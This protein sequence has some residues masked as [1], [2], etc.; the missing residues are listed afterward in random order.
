MAKI[1]KRRNPHIKKLS[2]L[3]M[4]QVLFAV[5]PVFLL[6][7]ILGFIGDEN[8]PLTLIFIGIVILIMVLYWLVARRYRII[9]SGY[10]G[11][12]TLKNIIKHLRWRD[13]TAI[14]TN[15]PICYNRRRSELDMLVVS[16]TGIFLIEAKNHSG[17]IYGSEADYTWLQKKYRK[18]G[19]I[20]EKE[21]ENP[22]RQTK[23]QRDILKS[24]LRSAGLDAWI[25]EII[26]FAN[27]KVKL[28][29]DLNEACVCGNEHELIQII[30]SFK[31]KIIAKKDYETIINLLADENNDK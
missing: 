21:I 25:N 16:E 30:N 28:K 11:E 5:I 27:P 17:T 14:F 8:L 10:H 15:L 4:T 12:R 1:Y 6:V 23:R 24:I 26:Y 9:L 20:S 18:N 3:F 13:H 31:K 7:M 2:L 29:L 19:K 22:L